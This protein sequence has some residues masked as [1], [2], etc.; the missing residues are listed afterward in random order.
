[1][2]VSAAASTWGQLSCTV[3]DVIFPAPLVIPEESTAPDGRTVQLVLTP[4]AANGHGPAAE[5]KLLSFDPAAVDF[6][7]QENGPETHA[8]GQLWREVG[9]APSVRSLD[10]LRARCPET[11][12]VGRFY[13]RAGD[14]HLSFGPAFRCVAEGW[15]GE[16]TAFARLR[17]PEAVGSVAGYAL[18]PGLLDGCFHVT[19]L[20]QD[21]ATAMETLLP[22]AVAELRLYETAHATAAT[23]EWWCYAEQTGEHRWDI[24]LLDEAGELIAAVQGYE[25]RVAAPEAV[26]GDNAWL[27]W[28]YQVAW[29]PHALFGLPLDFLLPMAQLQQARGTQVAEAPD[30]IARYQTGLT[31]LDALCIDYVVAALTKAGFTFQPGTTWRTESITQLVGVVPQYQRLL[32]RLL[33]MLTEVGIFRREGDRWQVVQQPVTADPMQA[34]RSLQENAG[35]VIGAELALVAQC[36]P[37]LSETWRGLQD[38]LDLLF[39]AGNEGSDNGSA[40]HFYQTSRTAQVA[41]ATVQQ[42]LTT[43]LAALPAGRG[44]RILE[45]GAGTGS[46]TAALL[47]H[48]PAAQIE[49]TFTD[50]GTAFLRQAQTAFGDYD[51]VHYRTLDIE[52]EP[53][54]QGF[55][56]HQYDVVIAANVLHATADLATTLR[57]I[58]QL[59]APNGLL[60]LLE[61][62]TRSRWIDL[63]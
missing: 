24:Q 23:G 20:I 52:Q 21:E 16:K 7:T 26:Q 6:T 50:I 60:L 40:T 61:G 34:L 54:R 38:P 18:H 59:L 49:Y 57:N 27:D 48:L 46:T 51:F 55:T 42:T 3:A 8:T 35:D 29:Q 31:A 45:V 41:N 19:G 14:Q 33:E 13:Q 53:T 2:A 63:T 9:A 22:F 62:T 17:L 25:A 56:P 10:E 11:V 30:V 15:R 39:P 58:H 12:D 37:K 28:L 43:V 32:I 36:A 4:L 44:L 5:F 1:L 47:P